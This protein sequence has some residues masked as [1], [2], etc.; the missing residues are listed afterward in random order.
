MGYE[1]GSIIETGNVSNIGEML[2]E[3]NGSDGFAKNNRWEI[4]ITPPTG[5]RG[6]SRG[7]VFAPI[8]GAKTLPRPPPL[9]PVGGVITI[10]QRL[11]LANPSFE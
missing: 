1:L 6:G 2:A 3:L 4:V 11:V 9:F 8:I 5:N 7:N 10:S